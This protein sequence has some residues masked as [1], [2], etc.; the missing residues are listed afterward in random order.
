MLTGPGVPCP[1]AGAQCAHAAVGA[2]EA[3]HAKGWAAALHHWEA[4]GQPKI[5]LQA[6]S[7][8]VSGGGS[9]GCSSGHP[10]VCPPCFGRAA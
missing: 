10:L 1:A 9:G 5:C 2:V 6:G 3:L 8:A 7:T 4:C